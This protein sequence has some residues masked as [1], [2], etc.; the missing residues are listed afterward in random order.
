MKICIVTLCEAVNYGAFLQ[1]YSLK[2]YLEKRGHTVFF[3]RTYS[4]PMIKTMIK[5]LY[6]YNVRK[7]KFKSEFRHGY[8]CMQKKWFF[9]L[10]RLFRT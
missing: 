4:K 9:S 6:T 2:I 10:D 1:A 3:L 8:F 7:M 5:S